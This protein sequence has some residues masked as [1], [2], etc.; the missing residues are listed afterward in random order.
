MGVSRNLEL[1]PQRC[2]E[3]S[4]GKLLLVDEDLEDLYYYSAILNQLGYEVRTFASYGEA[5]ALL[6]SEVFD[7]VVVSQ[8][9]PNFEGRN[10]LARAV[11][12]DRRIPVLVLTHAVEIPCYLEAMQLGARDYIEKPLPPSEIGTLVAKYLES[13]SGSA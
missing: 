3:S 4:R 2:W 5:A 10:V 6:G 1:K 9:T 8:G 7:L 12:R 13:R 11:E